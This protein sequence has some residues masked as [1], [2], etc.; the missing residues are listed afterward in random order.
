LRFGTANLGG[1]SWSTSRFLSLRFISISLRI[2]L[3]FSVSLDS[4]SRGMTSGTYCLAVIRSRFFKYMTSCLVLNTD[5]LSM[6]LMI[7]SMAVGI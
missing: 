1:F 6:S 7:L 3:V 2:S 5:L 4:S